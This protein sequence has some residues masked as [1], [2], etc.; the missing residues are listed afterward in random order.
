MEQ[1][2]PFPTTPWTADEAKEHLAQRYNTDE[3]VLD[4]WWLREEFLDFA[5]AYPETKGLLLTG[6]AGTTISDDGLAR[7]AKLQNVEWITIQAAANIRG[8]GFAAWTDHPNLLSI[9]ATASAIDDRG[10]AEIGR[11]KKL[12]ELDLGHTQ[13]TD[14]GMESV[15]KLSELTWLN[16]G[17]NDI[18]DAG[19]QV[20]CRALP[21]L[22]SLS[23]DATRVTSEIIPDIAKLENLRYL[24]LGKLSLSREFLQ[25]IGTLEQLE[26]LSLRWA[27]L[28][29]VDLSALSGLKNLKHLDLGRVNLQGADLSWIKHLQ[30]L[31]ELNLSSTKISDQEFQTLEITGPLRVLNLNDTEISDASL[32]KLVG[33]PL[34]KLAVASERITEA[35][36]ESIIKIKSLERLYFRMGAGSNVDEYNERLRKA[37]PNTVILEEMYSFFGE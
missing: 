30:A 22:E 17:E 4:M 25:Q 24:G 37:M 23:L 34:Q 26:K 35:S 2:D 21:K 3:K 12:D 7:L 16:L 19:V 14:K 33:S 15:A 13:V 11:L 9:F 31:E 18:S 5:L 6:I 29:V 28:D 8:T 20:V 10:L 36:M 32:H 1:H 27:D